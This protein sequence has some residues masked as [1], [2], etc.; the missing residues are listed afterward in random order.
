M[1]EIAL[2]EPASIF[3]QDTDVFEA[4]ERMHE[5]M[6]TELASEVGETYRD[7]VLACLEGLRYRPPTDPEV[8]HDHTD[9]D[10]ET[11]LKQDLL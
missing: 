5:V 4:L 8:N 7:A 3:V 9:P 10:P 2:W 6:K 11:G 1:S